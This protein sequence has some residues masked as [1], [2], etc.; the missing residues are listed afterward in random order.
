MAQVLEQLGWGLSSSAPPGCIG[1]TTI[2]PGP[3]GWELA[4]F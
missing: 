4:V 3:Q 1:M 2:T